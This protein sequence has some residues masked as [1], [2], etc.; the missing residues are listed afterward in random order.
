MESKKNLA[1]FFWMHKREKEVDERVRITSEI[2]GVGF[3]DLLDRKPKTLSGGQQ[4][5][6]AI[7]RCI[8]RD[9]RL[10]L[11]DEPLSNL[12]AKLRSK[13]RVEIKRLLNRFKITAIY[14]THDQVEAIALGDRICVMRHGKIEQVGTYWDIYRPPC[15]SVRRRLRRRAADEPDRRRPWRT[16]S[17]ASSAAR[18]RWTSGS[19]RLVSAGQTVTLGARPQHVIVAAPGRAGLVRRPWSRWSSRSRPSGSRSCTCSR[20]RPTWGR[21]SGSRSRR[22]C[23][24]RTAFSE[25]TTSR[26][27]LD[28]ARI[29]LFD[30]DSDASARSYSRV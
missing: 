4:Q 5:R 6:V 13:T 2:L 27:T 24:S 15:E 19:A 25:A 3:E 8:I 22:T 14:V 7:G 28:A 11:F 21:P 23:R 20:A 17:C 9:P 26:S 1:F 18:F 12:D 29:H 16:D 30:P 10:F